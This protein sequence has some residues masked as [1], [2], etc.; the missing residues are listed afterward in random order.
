M[1]VCEKIKSAMINNCFVSMFVVIIIILLSTMIGLGLIILFGI[2]TSLIIYPEYDIHTGCYQSNTM[3]DNLIINNTIVDNSIINNTLICPTKYDNICYLDNV[4]GFVSGCGLIGMPSFLII[5]YIIAFIRLVFRIHI[6]T[7]RLRQASIPYIEIIKQLFW[8]DIANYNNLVDYNHT[9]QLDQSNQSDHIIYDTLDQFVLSSI[10]ITIIL[11]I[12]WLISVLF[13]IIT[14]WLM[15]G[16]TYNL[17]TNIDL[18]C[19]LSNNFSIFG[20]CFAVGLIPNIIIFLIIIIF[21]ER[22]KI[23]K[24]ELQLIIY[25]NQSTQFLG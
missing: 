4:K 1:D 2:I 16:R 3:V 25:Q 20:K 22:H 15:Y 9:N 10:V 23:Q 8:N 19:N 18:F 11:T 14:T 17:I 5:A 24:L 12:A 6:R 21:I 7:R 13:G